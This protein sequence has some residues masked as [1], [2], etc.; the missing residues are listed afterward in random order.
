MYFRS[1]NS[2]QVIR[3]SRLTRTGEKQVLSSSTQLEA[4]AF[5]ISLRACTAYAQEGKPTKLLASKVG[6]VLG[7]S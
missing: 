1:S 3:L 6:Q 7:L 4:E 5:V 2:F